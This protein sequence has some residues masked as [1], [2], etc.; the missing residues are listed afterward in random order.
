MNVCLNSY[1]LD[2]FLIPAAYLAVSEPTA[3]AE[4][5]EKRYS[6]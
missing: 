4:D 6:A 3:A 5:S 1:A 2:L